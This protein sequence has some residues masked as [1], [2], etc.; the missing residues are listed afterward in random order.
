MK[1]TLNFRS[2]VFKR[3][4]QLVRQTGC[5]FSEALKEAWTRYRQY[6]D[7][8]AREIASRI[9]GFD[10]NYHYSDDHRVYKQW[11]EAE[12]QIRE[13]LTVNRCMIS[14][15]ASQLKSQSLISRFV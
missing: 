13:M 9:N 8:L 11:S 2:V 15:I 1:A 14:A 10:F 3:A 6:R 12:R 7:K 5:S 4:Y